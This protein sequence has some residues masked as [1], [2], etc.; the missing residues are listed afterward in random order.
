MD[1]EAAAYVQGQEV[2]QRLRG[3][4]R[5]IHGLVRLFES[6]GAEEPRRIRKVRE[7][8]P[9]HKLSQLILDV[10]YRMML[11]LGNWFTAVALLLENGYS[12][13]QASRET[14]RKQARYLPPIHVPVGQAHKDLER[15]LAAGRIE[16]QG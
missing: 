1:I 13:F 4:S 3:A 6:S 5:S 11:N 16:W 7:L 12:A 2:E 8:Y 14:F 9:Y 15:L 10:L